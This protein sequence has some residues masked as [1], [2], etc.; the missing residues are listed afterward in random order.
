MVLASGSTVW[1]M[2][3]NGVRAHLPV[4]VYALIADQFAVGKCQDAVSEGNQ[5][6][7]MSHHHDSAATHVGQRVEDGSYSTTGYRIQS[8]RWLIGQQQAR[9]HQHR[10]RDG[11]TLLLPARELIG[12]SPLQPAQTQLAQ[13]GAGLLGMTAQRACGVNHTTGNGDVLPYTQRG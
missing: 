9:F 4:G 3:G 2:D 7:I 13:K 12:K 10:S 11:H 5:S 1:W 8:S 6:S